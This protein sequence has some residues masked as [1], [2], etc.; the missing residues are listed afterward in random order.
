MTFPHSSLSAIF[1][2]Q[3]ETRGEAALVRRAQPCRLEERLPACRHHHTQLFDHGRS[4]IGAEIEYCCP[5]K[6]ISDRRIATFRTHS[7]NEPALQTTLGLRTDVIER[8]QSPNRSVEQEALATPVTIDVRNPDV[9]HHT[10][11]PLGER[12]AHIPGAMPDGYS[13][14]PT[15]QS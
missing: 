12:P 5:G 10:A 9:D 4:F 13:Q 14:I 1:T 7:Q 3:P 11:Q 6:R 8:R 15:A 2:R